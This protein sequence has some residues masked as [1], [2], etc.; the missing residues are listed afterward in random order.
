MTDEEQEKLDTMLMYALYH[1]KPMEEIKGYIDAGANINARDPDGRT[2]LMQ[3]RTAEKTKFLLEAGADPNIM[4]D[5]GY[6]AYD[7][8]R[9]PE[10]RK[11]LKPLC[12]D[13]LEK[14]AVKHHIEERKYQILKSRKLRK[15]LE[16]RN[17]MEKVS[18]VALADEIAEDVISGKEKRT[19]T[20]EV[21]AEYRRR[22]AFE[23]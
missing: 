19:I 20:P 22:K 9:T 2:P 4:D 17:P 6:I 7:H 18:G 10:Q 11:I 16:K 3:A 5:D 13:I 21:G 8:N 15:K 23:K 12:R 1:D 14:R